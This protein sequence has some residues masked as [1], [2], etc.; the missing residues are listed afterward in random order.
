MVVEYVVG[1]QVY[2]AVITTADI[3]EDALSR[4]FDVEID[5]YP[6]WLVISRS[7]QYAWGS[8]A[9]IQMMREV[10]RN[11]RGHGGLVINTGRARELGLEDGDQVEI[12]SPLCATRG[13]V[14]TR[15]GIRPDTLLR[16]GQFD[17]WA[18]PL[19]KGFDMPSMNRLV[20]MLMDLTDSTGSSA[21]LTRVQVTKLASAG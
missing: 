13:V 5:D 3:V 21:D 2:A 15:Q 19:A 16:I 12:R 10:A 20:P 17:H 1:F 4:H 18:T 14:V 6:F 7:M 11:V 9:A 8:N